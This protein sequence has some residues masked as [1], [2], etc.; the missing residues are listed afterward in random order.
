[1]TA[2]P[3]R[4]T[5]FAVSLLSFMALGSS[6]HSDERWGSFSFPWTQEPPG[7]RHRVVRFVT[8]GQRGVQILQMCRSPLQDFLVSNACF[9]RGLV[10]CAIAGEVAIIKAAAS[11]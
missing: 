2:R 6:P 7:P 4:A 5:W 10:A 11:K 8:P 9:V 3:A 1:M